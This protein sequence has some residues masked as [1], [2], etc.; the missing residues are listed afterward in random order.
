[1]DVTI[2]TWERPESPTRSSYR[3]GDRVH[4]RQPTSPGPAV[5]GL[6]SSKDGGF[7]Q[8]LGAHRLQ[9]FIHAQGLSIT[10]EAAT[11][12]LRR[13]SEPESFEQR[14]PLIIQSHYTRLSRGKARRCAD[15]RRSVGRRDGD[16]VPEA[17]QYDLDPKLRNMHQWKITLRM[18]TSLAEDLESYVAAVHFTLPEGMF[19]PGKG[20]IDPVVV[21][22][23]TSS[24][25]SFDLTVTSAASLTLRVDLYSTIEQL[26]RSNASFT[27]PLQV[28]SRLHKKLVWFVFRSDAM[29]EAEE[30]QRHEMD[31]QEKQL[32]KVMGWSGQDAKSG[33]GG[34]DGDDDED[35][36]EDA[37][38]G[39]SAKGGPGGSAGGG[40]ESELDRVLQ[41]ALDAEHP[42]ID[43][44]GIQTMKGFIA[45]GRFTHEHY[46]KMWTK[47]LADMG[48]SV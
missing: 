21:C 1:M 29:V 47:R 41:I 43:E 36:D 27:Y 13:D 4:R 18:A 16:G 15:C 11:A 7:R 20:H 8:A 37:D 30:A 23:E 35:E 32:R 24:P 14:V 2:P 9:A 22:E 12:L 33:G 10:R 39:T 31:D 28:G 26:E 25:G 48:I 45:S 38:D 5:S 34:D 3:P 17:A 46:L 42:G 44:E 6:I 19:A 40:Q